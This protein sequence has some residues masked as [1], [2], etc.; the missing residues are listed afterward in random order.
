MV[1]V[2]AGLGALVIAIGIDALITSSDLSPHVRAMRAKS[3]VWPLVSVLIGL[4]VGGILAVSRRRIE[5]ADPDGRVGHERRRALKTDALI[6]RL[7]AL[8]LVAVET[9]FLIFAGGPLWTE[10]QTFFGATSGEVALQRAVGSA[11]VGFGNAQVWQTSQ[12][13]EF[14]R[15]PI[16]ATAYMSCRFTTPLWHQRPI[17]RP[18][19]ATGRQ[20]A[21]LADGVFCPSITTVAI[22]KR[23]GIAYVLEP[24]GRAGPAGSVF[25]EDIGGEGLY[26][27]PGAAA[28][29]LAPDSLDAINTESPL[30]L[31][32]PYRYFIPMMLPGVCK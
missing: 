27:I 13:S 21:P 5:R 24:P 26:F 3:F 19:E 9:F 8:L 18:G 2:W 30:E 11:T 1:V 15:K 17:T 10:G 7:S 29:T 23:Y 6:R 28:A 31:G 14:F 16:S 20:V 22:A 12:I 4:F 32:H 25:K